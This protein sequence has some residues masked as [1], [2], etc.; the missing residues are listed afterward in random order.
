MCWIVLARMENIS[1]QA[2]V[3]SYNMIK[4]KEQARK[5]GFENIKVNCIYLVVSYKGAWVLPLVY[6]S[7]CPQLCQ[8][9]LSPVTSSRASLIQD[10]CTQDG[11]L[12][13]FTMVDVV[14]K[15]GRDLS[16][17]VVKFEIDV[18]VPLGRPRLWDWP[19]GIL[20]WVESGLGQE[21]W[22]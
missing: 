4:E 22:H 21:G 8:V 9:L 11:C 1:S 20:R 18:G 16:I 3:E 17:L 14:S 19:L 5:W 6:R 10:R 12:N 7:R 13:S 2:L 15:P